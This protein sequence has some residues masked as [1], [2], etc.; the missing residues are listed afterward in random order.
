MY[1]RVDFDVEKKLKWVSYE[2]KII[3]IDYV[4]T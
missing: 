3:M 2:N 4:I 1:A